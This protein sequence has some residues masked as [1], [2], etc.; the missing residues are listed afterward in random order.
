MHDTSYSTVY[1]VSYRPISKQVHNL[2]ICSTVQLSY[3][4]PCEFQICM[5]FWK[6][7]VF[8]GYMVT[9]SDPRSDQPSKLSENCRAN[10]FSKL[11][12]H[13]LLSKKLYLNFLLLKNRKTKVS[14]WFCK[15]YR[16]PIFLLTYFLGY[17]YLMVLSHV[18]L[19]ANWKYC[20][21]LNRTTKEEPA[22]V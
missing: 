18:I 17:A 13:T 6:H 22:L 21:K 8:T 15:Q 5:T 20:A 16:S 3:R 12:P 14:F 11:M 4:Y 7:N 19:E 9:R 2:T 10:P 1:S